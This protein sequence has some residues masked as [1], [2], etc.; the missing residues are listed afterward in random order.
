MRFLGYPWHAIGGAAFA[1]LWIS[2]IRQQLEAI[3]WL[4]GWLQ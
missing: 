3:I 4:A 2:T 1:T